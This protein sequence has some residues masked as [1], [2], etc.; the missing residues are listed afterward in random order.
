MSAIETA[1]RIIV[2]LLV[3]GEYERAERVTRGRRLSATDL[4]D[5]V[6]EY[7]RTLIPPQEG[8]WEEVTVTPMEIGEAAAFHVAAPLWT[9]EEGRSD[10][11]L[12]MHLRAIGIELYEA[13]ILNVL[14]L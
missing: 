12:E 10:L 3:R 13:E 8:W 9:R 11:S 2:D 7:G 5:A 6:A 1:V 4:S 14:V